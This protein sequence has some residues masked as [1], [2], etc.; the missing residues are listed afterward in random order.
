MFLSG[1][2]ISQQLVCLAEPMEPEVFTCTKV[3]G[4][5]RRDLVATY[6]HISKWDVSAVNNMSRLFKDGHKKIACSPTCVVVQGDTCSSIVV[7]R[8]ILAAL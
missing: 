1:L 5:G 7:G 6:G 2:E 8:C 4:T 3:S